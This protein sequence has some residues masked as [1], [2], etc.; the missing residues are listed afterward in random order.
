MWLCG[1]TVGYRCAI[2]MTCALIAAVS[3]VGHAESSGADIDLDSQAFNKVYH[4][5]IR[6]SDVKR[7]PKWRKDAENP[8]VSARKAISLA[9][10]L[11]KSLILDSK[12]Y[13]WRLNHAQLNPY[14][15]PER[16]YWEVEFEADRTDVS[17]ETGLAPVFRAVILMDGTVVKPIVTPAKDSP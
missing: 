7:A 13:H 16:W 4:T 2:V 6:E 14:W 12:R 3:E 9:A 15:L 11:R 10:E 1:R 17:N 8:P 5:V